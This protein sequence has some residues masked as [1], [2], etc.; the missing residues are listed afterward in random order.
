MKRLIILTMALL[1]I[2]V[3]NRAEATYK[4]YDIVAKSSKEKIT[5]YAKKIDGLYQDFKIQFRDELYSR[6]FWINV[7]NPSY[8][9]QIYYED[10]DK[11]KIKELIIILTKGY[12]TGAVDQ[13]VYVYRY[14]NGLIEVLVDNPLAI[15][16]KNVKTKLTKKEAKLSIG[17]NN[18]VL[19]LSPVGIKPENIFN[20]VS[21]GGII[22]Y[23]VD[24]NQLIARVAAQISPAYFIGEVIIPY[25]YRDKMYQAKSID[26]QPYQ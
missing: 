1:L 24:K 20:D 26:F 5:L 18:Y 21:F 23:E 25:E 12:G 7:T 3:P 11:D 8:S 19:D 13:E 2:I 17:N 16:N 22:K 9:P 6:P 15:I 10:I 14:T 4:G